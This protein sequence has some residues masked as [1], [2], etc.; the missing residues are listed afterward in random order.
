MKNVS[1]DDY[2]MMKMF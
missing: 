2:M 1:Y